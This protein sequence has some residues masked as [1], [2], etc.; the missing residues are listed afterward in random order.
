M[1]GISLFFAKIIL[2]KVGQEITKIL[3]MK[4]MRSIILADSETIDKKHS[5][6]FISHLTFDV[7]M[8]TKLVSTVILNLIRLSL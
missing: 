2:I 7:T 4:I 1:E 6:K 8:I 3:Q 5:G